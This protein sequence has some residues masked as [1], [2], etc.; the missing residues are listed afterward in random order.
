MA[1]GSKL[2]MIDVGSEA[3]ALAGG[4]LDIPTAR[5]LFMYNINYQAGARIQCSSWGESVPPTPSAPSSFP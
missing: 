4:G 3:G 5:G 2:V 1:P